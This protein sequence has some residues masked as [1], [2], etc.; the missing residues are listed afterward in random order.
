VSR[1]P[2]GRIRALSMR[3]TMTMPTRRLRCIC[4]VSERERVGSRQVKG[5]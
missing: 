4:V 5:V 1:Y 3:T 2:P